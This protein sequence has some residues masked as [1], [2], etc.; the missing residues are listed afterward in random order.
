V[1]FRFLPYLLFLLPTTIVRAQTN[2]LAMAYGIGYTIPNH[3]DFPEV[4]G[5]SNSIELGWSHKQNAFWSL[6]NGGAVFHLNATFQNF[7]NNAVL[8][9]AFALTPAMS[10][11][12]VKKRQFS[13]SLNF[14]IITYFQFELYHTICLN[15]EYGSVIPIL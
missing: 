14:I 3:P 7:G 12:I 13:N 1:L 2:S 9:Q 5:P 15:F 11:P 8:G 4:K 10:Y 6:L